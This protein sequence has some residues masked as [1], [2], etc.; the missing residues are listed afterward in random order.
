[1]AKSTQHR[2]RRADNADRHALYEASVQDTETELEFV[3]ET[4]QEVTG[5]PLK[6]LREDFCGTANT[7]AAW[8]RLAADHE[9]IGVD[10]D[11][12]VLDWGLSLIHI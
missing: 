4:F 6:C 12:E 7:A 3:A 2:S 8:V 10:L 9:A 5:R 11:G 1:M